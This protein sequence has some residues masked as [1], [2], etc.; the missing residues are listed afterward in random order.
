MNIFMLVV[1]ILMAITILPHI[2]R[3]MATKSSED[4]SI[5]GIAGIAAGIMSWLI[6]GVVTGHPTIVVCNIVL[7]IVQMAYLG[8]AVYYRRKGEKCLISKTKLSQI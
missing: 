8:T 7:F 1:S 4:Q 3:M 2:K 6:Y 5:I